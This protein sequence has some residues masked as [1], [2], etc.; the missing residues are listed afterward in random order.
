MTKQE[1]VGKYW[2]AAKAACAGTGIFPETCF[3]EMALESAWGAS[4]LTVH[5]NNFLGIKSTDDWVKHGG[6]I[7]TMHTK[8]QKEDGTPYIIEADFRLYDSPE[9]CFKNYVHFVTQPHYIAAG[10]LKAKTPEDQAK[11]LQKAGYA[12]AVNYADVII[13]IMHGLKPYLK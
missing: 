9:D 11:V 4:Y 8:E 12:T 1:F 3:S 6:K 7:I 2:N 10:I 13:S 5:A